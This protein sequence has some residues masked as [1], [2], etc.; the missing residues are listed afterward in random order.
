MQM[1]SPADDEIA[2]GWEVSRTAEALAS[3]RTPKDRELRAIANLVSKRNYEMAERQLSRF[4][5]RNPNSADALHMMGQIAT[6]TKRDEEAERLFCRS[7]DREPDFGIVRFRY[8]STLIRLNK[9]AEAQQQLHQLLARDPNNM[10]Y[11]DLEALRLT[12]LEQHADAAECYRLLT[13][14]YPEIGIFWLRYADRLRALGDQENCVRAYRKVLE[15]CPSI[16][17]AYWSLG[18]LKTFRF[19]DADVSAMEGQL[20]RL[21]L[22]SHNRAYF[23]FALGKAYA[24]RSLHAKAFESYSKGNSLKRITIDYD[25]ESDTQH[26]RELRKLF[27]QAFFDDRAGFGATSPAP[28]FVVGM[29]RAGSTLVEQILCSHSA[30][31]SIGEARDIPLLSARLETVYASRFATP[32]PDVIGK[33]DA[34]T[35][36]DFGEEYLCSTASRRFLDARHFVDKN[37]SNFWCVGLIH[38]ILPN[39]KIVDVRR[40]PMACCFSNYTMNYAK[41]MD[42]TYRLNELGRY[43]ADY[44]G[45]MAHYDRVLPGVVHRVIYEDLV[46]DIEAEL[47][48]LLDYLDLPFEIDCLRFHESRRAVPTASSEQ[49]RRPI[50]NE[51]LTR[52]RDY[53]PWLGSLKAALGPVLEAYPDAPA[54]DR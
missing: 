23:H 37:P 32:Y 52:W 43:Y 9:L 8:A 33:L 29:H 46:A 22:S 45:L 27:S 50:N 5:K 34:D 1:P 16:G 10:L 44:V 21:D 17:G 24:D 35:A 51:G 30:V 11:R 38:L 20:K 18:D 3:L 26:V 7:L 6:A 54:L 14:D 4:L 25:S 48:R 41:G 39:A 2:L 31:E 49:V 13:Q 47:R 19:T 53:E 12:R 36:R 42:H 15:L 40:N 28:I